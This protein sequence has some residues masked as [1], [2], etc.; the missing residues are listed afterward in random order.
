M[1]VF[2]FW[3][4]LQSF[5]LFYHA[6]TKYNVFYWVIFFPSD[7]TSSDIIS[8]FPSDEVLLM[9]LLL[10]KLVLSVIAFLMALSYWIH[11]FFDVMNVF[12]E[13]IMIFKQI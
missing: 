11:Y 13:F 1:P 3:W 10:L 2:N 12:I 8:F 5:G 6:V 4:Q 7:I 9:S